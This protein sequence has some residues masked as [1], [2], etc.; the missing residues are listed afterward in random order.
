MQWVSVTERRPK[1]DPNA[2]YSEVPCLVCH[3][4]EIKILVFN[5]EHM[6]WDDADGDDFYCKTM[7]VSH[8]MELP[9]PPQFDESEHPDP[10]DAECCEGCRKPAVCH[11]RE[12]VPLCGQCAKALADEV[13]TEPDPEEQR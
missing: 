8:W 3:K 10:E 6:C 1:R 7:E 11:D 5:H 4:G 9:P 13:G 12:G 2:R